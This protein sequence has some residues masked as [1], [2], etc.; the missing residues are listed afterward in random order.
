MQAV[1]AIAGPDGF[2]HRLTLGWLREAICKPLGQLLGH[3]GSGIVSPLIGT[4]QNFFK[5]LFF[6]SLTSC[7]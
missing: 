6:P 2:W 5:L 3:M 1:E 7:F 4:T